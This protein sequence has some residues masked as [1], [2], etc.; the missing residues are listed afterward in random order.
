MQFALSFLE[1]LITFISPCLLPLLPLYVSYF[2]AGKA[3]KRTSLV[4]AS[5]FVAGFTLV[6]V[7]LGAFAGT[8]GRL[9]VQ[10]AAAVNIATGL[11]V[12][13]LGLNFIGLIKILPLPAR[14]MKVNV[15]NLNFFSAAGF[16]AVFSISWTPCAG[17]FLGAALMR[18]SMQ[19]GLLDGA[20][21]L[22]VYSLG[23]GI[24]FIASAV[25]IDKLKDAFDFIKRH[26]GVIKVVSG[27]ML[28]V[29]GLLMATGLMGRILALGQAAALGRAWL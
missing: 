5:G 9:L 27:S 18:A 6:F 17:A 21:L 15:E 14:D 20:L 23:L 22:L 29:M 7:A 19:G 28:I 24:P 12:I 2:A 8:L 3:D 13:A 4:N 25:L 16:G 10:Y 11:V 1:G 26:Y